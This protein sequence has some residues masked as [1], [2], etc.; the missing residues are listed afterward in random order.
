[1]ASKKKSKGTSKSKT[2]KTSKT[3]KPISPIGGGQAGF[4]TSMGGPNSRG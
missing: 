1:M 4:L 2:A 3:P